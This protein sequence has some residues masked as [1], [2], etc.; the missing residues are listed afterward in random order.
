MTLA[1]KNQTK[2]HGEWPSRL[3]ALLFTGVLG[4]LFWAS[5]TGR[6]LENQLGLEWL[7]GLRGPRVP[8]PEVLVVPISARS[9]DALSQPSIDRLDNWDRKL[10]AQLVERLSGAGASVIAFD[11]AFLEESADREADESFAGA[12][13]RAG[14]V[15]L[16]EWLDQQRLAP[17]MGNLLAVNLDS[18]SGPTD[19]FASVAAAVAPWPLFKEARTDRFPTFPSIAGKTAPTLPVAALHLHQRGRIQATRPCFADAENG[20]VH[21][22]H[23][24]VVSE[25][26]ALR[27]WS[28]S[29]GERKLS[30]TLP[31]SCTG[32]YIPT[33]KRLYGVEEETYFN[34]YG[35]AGTLIGPAI[36][37]WL[38]PGPPP[39][40][41]DLTDK[42][43]F[44]GV[45]EYV[46]IQQPDSFYTV[47]RS[48][49][50][51]TDISGVELAATA[52]ANLLHEDYLRPAEPFLNILILLAFGALTGVSGYRFP[53]KFAIAAVLS[54]ATLYGLAAHHSFSSQNLW[55]P[56]VVPLLIQVPA[57]IALGWHLRFVRARRMKEVYRGAVEHYV[58]AH[59]VDRIERVG[60][61]GTVPEPMYGVCMHS[62]IAGY[63]TLAER[64]SSEPLVLKGL[65]T[66]Y[67]ELLGEEIQQEEGQMLEIAGD[68]MICIWA[69]KTLETGMQ[70]RACRAAVGMLR[71]VERY[72]ARH[73]DTPFPT[74]IGIHAGK[75]ALGNV[76]GGGHYTWAVGGDIANTAARL[77]NDLNKLLHTRM[78]VSAQSID[79]LGE[80]D[81]EGLGLKCIGTFKLRG[82]TNAIVAYELSESLA[83]QS[84]VDPVQ[85]EAAL[86]AFESGQWRRAAAAFERLSGRCPNDGPSCFYHRLSSSYLA[87][88][89][90]PPDPDQPGLIDMNL[91]WVY[92]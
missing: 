3:L 34:Y 20:L 31:S 55:L 5:P 46:S 37:E 69:G 30:E 11:I 58:P 53:A 25:M 14:N 12:I 39:T 16:L 15:V 66:E 88:E 35:M 78:V 32:P 13:G 48:E 72:N 74:R 10:F 41:I 83:G 81:R 82:K 57:A 76:G 6:H 24:P 4:V 85:F 67:W 75:V 61:I 19:T 9:A 17:A 84:R 7:F 87:G 43:I 68:G 89:R 54:I 47:F 73:P 59:I 40:G 36:H 33:L 22:A 63:T 65:E 79:T 70:A 1:P 77:E 86:A 8:A 71:A 21:S 27:A 51:N 52:F 80:R 18:L 62:D 44:V 90:Q 42:A 91:D 64:F 45:A 49:R 60:H 29:M 92:P 26:L 28:M 38:N 56:L 2:R 23:H 50:G